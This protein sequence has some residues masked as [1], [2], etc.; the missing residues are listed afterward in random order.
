MFGYTKG[1]LYLCLDIASLA[2]G[3]TGVGR[4]A[5]GFQGFCL[6]LYGSLA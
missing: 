2:S 5:A 4:K 3:T 1:S 6:R